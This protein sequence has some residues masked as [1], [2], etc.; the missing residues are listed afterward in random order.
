[1]VS[2]LENVSTVS[3]VFVSQSKLDTSPAR[4]MARRWFRVKKLMHSPF[5]CLM[6]EERYEL[7]CIPIAKTLPMLNDEDSV[8]S[9]GCPSLP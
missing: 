2:L 1:M 8:E 7:A 6:Q 9:L 5:L 4:S 3:A